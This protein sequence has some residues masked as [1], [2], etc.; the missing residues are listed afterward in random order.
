M[1]KNEHRKSHQPQ[2]VPGIIS[3]RP[4]TCP[5]LPKPHISPDKKGGAGQDF[6]CRLYYEKKSCKQCFLLF[7]MI[8]SIPTKYEQNIDE[9]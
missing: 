4:D 1:Q 6:S 9:I 3:V 7:F 2:R 5:A 8:L